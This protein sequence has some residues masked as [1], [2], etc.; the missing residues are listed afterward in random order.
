MNRTILSPLYNSQITCNLRSYL[1]HA[2]GLVVKD[3][4]DPSGRL[5]VGL[6]DVDDDEGAS[7][8]TRR[9]AVPDTHRQVV[10]PGA[11]LQG[12]A[13]GDEPRRRADDEQTWRGRKKQLTLL[14][15]IKLDVST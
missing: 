6:D 14:Y 9:A 5:V 1:Q 2:Y 12:L 3:G 7:H 13:C 11:S 15:E 4:P 10:L 8:E